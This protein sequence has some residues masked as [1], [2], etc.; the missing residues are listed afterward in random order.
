MKSVFS[1]FALAM[2]AAC[3]STSASPSYGESL[4][5]VP[6][7]AAPE[8]ARLQNPKPER[9][10]FVGNSYL[11]YNDSLHNH[12]RR[13]VDA[14]DVAELEELTYKSATI[15]GATLRDHAIDHLLVPANLRVAAPFEV[16]ILQGGSAEPLSEAGRAGFIATASAYAAKVRAAGGEPVLYMTPAYVPPHRRYRPEMIEDIAS[17]Y[18]ETGNEIDAMVIPVGL[19]F[20]EAYRRRPEIE[21]HK[22]FDGSHPSMLGTYLAAAITFESLYGVSPVG[23]TYDYYGAI[24]GDDARFLQEVAHD[25]VTEF[26]RRERQ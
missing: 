19:A 18:L 22:D 5:T 13:M 26:Y 23:N 14:A 12:V 16:V 10:L 25:T 20:A 17:L 3:A 7:Y 15:G 9:I 1:A 11:Y 8:V 2:L 6:A 24:N 4:S 21:L